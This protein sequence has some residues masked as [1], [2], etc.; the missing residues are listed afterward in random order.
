MVEMKTFCQLK[1]GESHR[2]S[3]WLEL[4]CW[5][6]RTTGQFNLTTTLMD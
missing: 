5:S 6:H 1:A 4:P 3:A 2:L